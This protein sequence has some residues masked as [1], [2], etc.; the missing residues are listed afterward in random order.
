MK[1]LASMRPSPSLVL[2]VIAVLIALGGQ[3]GA[4]PGKH[5]VGKGD[6]AR[7][8]VTSRSLATGAVTDRAIAKRTIHGSAIA[9]KAIKSRMLA[10]GSVD[11][12]ALGPVTV[13]E[14]Q[15]PDLDTA[16][17]STY[18]RSGASL[19][20]PGGQRLLS[21]GVRSFADRVLMVSSRPGANADRWE[22]AIASDAGGAFLAST[23][24]V[25]CLK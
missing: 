22:G 12:R 15:I 21:G 7:G 4:L 11:S 1:R 19:A 13:V 3:A 2:S 20:C 6:I 25:L 23:L 10:P 17:D 8:A 9:S 18:T 16:V 24:D 5:S 14:T